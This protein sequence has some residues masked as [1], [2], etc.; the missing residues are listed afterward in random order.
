MPKPPRDSANTFGATDIYAGH[1]L[2]RELRNGL[3]WH[4][5]S[6]KDYRKMRADGA[7]KPNDG[8]VNRWGRPYACQQLGGISLFDFTTQSE[9]RVLGEAI[10]WR[11]FLGDSGPLTML[12]GLE[13][14]R[15]SGRL[16]SYPANKEGTTG[17]VIP[18]VEVCHCGPIALSAVVSHLLV[19]SADYGRFS[20]CNELEDQ[21]LDR[22]ESEFVG[23]VRIAD[24]KA[25][26]RLGE[27]NKAIR[28]LTQSP[29]FKA[30]LERATRNL[31]ESE[32]END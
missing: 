9:E 7:I 14:S 26:R 25:A 18:W 23:V 22:V 16:V 4:R 17:N 29:E 8:R 21:T 13:K 30:Q 27:M 24:E 12:L 32:G 19:C 6:T 11:Q 15:L 2:F 20:V 5:T 28:A 3:L 31:E 10:K 1:P